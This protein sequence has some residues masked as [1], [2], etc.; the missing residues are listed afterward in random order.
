MVSRDERYAR[1]TMLPEIGEEGQRRLAASSVLIVGLGGLGSAVAPYLTGAGVGRLGLA[2]PDR[3]SASNLPRQTLYTESQIGRPK[4]EAAR[5]RLAGLNAATRFDLYPEGL[6]A[7]NAREL[8]AAYDLVVDCCDNFATRY[9]LD[10][11]CAAV[12]RPWVYGSIG[13]FHGQVSLFN[14]PG[15]RRYTELYPDREVLC[16]LPPAAAGVL[17][18]TPGVVGALEAAEAIKWLAGFGELLDG[19][20]LTLDLKTMQTETIEF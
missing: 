19:R 12:G 6:T 16:A 2:D 4:P 8:V 14:G 13:A 1:Q 11:A 9:L 3:V 20:L 5:E 18:P 10:E 7:A 15:G 17:G